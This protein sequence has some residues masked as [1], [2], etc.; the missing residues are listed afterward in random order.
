MLLKRMLLILLG[1]IAIVFLIIY[2]WNK[3]P[4]SNF[5]F[6]VPSGFSFVPIVVGV[7]N[8]AKASRK[9]ILRATILGNF[10]DYNH[11]GPKLQ[12]LD[13]KDQSMYFTM[14]DG[15]GLPFRIS[16][17]DTRNVWEMVPT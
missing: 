5:P 4:I 10:F 16:D 12:P 7:Q 3:A 13:W 14:I 6:T 2:G 1:S 15:K 9:F 17:S 11:V 8:M